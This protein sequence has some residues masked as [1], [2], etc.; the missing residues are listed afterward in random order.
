M[1]RACMRYCTVVTRV[2]DQVF[3]PHPDWQARSRAGRWPAYRGR[4][5]GSIRLGRLSYPPILYTPGQ[6]S[7]GGRC[8]LLTTLFAD[9]AVL[10]C[11]AC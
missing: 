8:A 2:P 9:T 6:T 1:A 7:S 10:V 5:G 3:S 4:C 11:I